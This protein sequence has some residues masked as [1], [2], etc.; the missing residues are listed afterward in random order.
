MSEKIKERL[1]D[2][3]NAHNIEYKDIMVYQNLKFFFYPS[4]KYEYI[5]P[6]HKVLLTGKRNGNKKQRCN[7]NDE[8]IAIFMR[9]YYPYYVLASFIVFGVTIFNSL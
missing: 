2:F 8:K 7:N 1:K 9:Q 5:N 4:L 3:A 6:T